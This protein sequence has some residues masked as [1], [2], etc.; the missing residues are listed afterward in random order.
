MLFPIK[1][2]LEG[3]D[4]PLCVSKDTKI[5]QALALMVQH[6]Y[7][8][9][10]IVDAGGRLAGLISEQSVVEMYYHSNGVVPLLDLPVTHLH[11]PRYDAGWAV[12]PEPEFVAAQRRLVAGA[13]WIADGNSL[14]NL[15]IRAAAADTIIL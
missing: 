7:S 2:L 8:Q 6:D 5:A 11:H 1:P 10:P 4:A 12:V 9:L 15:P 3:R 14:A 13:R